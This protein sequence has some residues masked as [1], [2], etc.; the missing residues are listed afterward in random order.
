MIELAHYSALAPLAFLLA[1]RRDVRAA[2]WIVSIAFAV[3]FFADT[4]AA[5]MGGSWAPT[6]V[7]PVV[8]FGLVA[9]AFGGYVWGLVVAAAVLLTVTDVPPALPY[10]VGS[11]AVMWLAREHKLA[12]PVLVYFGLGTALYLGMIRHATPEA[13]EPFM[14]WWYPYQAARLSA[15]GLFM[16]AAWKEG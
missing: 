5:F 16:H 9:L 7:Y 14:R 3:S 13:Y 6:S 11:M 2:Y 15:F 8:Q 12:A 10:A 1:F 4:V